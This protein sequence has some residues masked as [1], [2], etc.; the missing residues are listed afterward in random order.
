[1]RLS[2]DAT[3]TKISTKRAKRDREGVVVEEPA[4]AVT[5]DVPVS[6]LSPASLGA[7]LR[8]MDRELRVELDDGQLGFEMIERDGARELV[9]DRAP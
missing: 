9:P 1:M 3:L 6:S 2:F 8:A 4:I 7:L 5:V